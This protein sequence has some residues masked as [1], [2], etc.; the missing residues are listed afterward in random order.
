MKK[1]I[2]YSEFLADAKTRKSMIYRPG[3]ECVYDEGELP[4]GIDS[5]EVDTVIHLQKQ[6]SAANVPGTAEDWLKLGG[7]GNPEELEM[8]TDK[9]TLGYP[10]IEE[11]QHHKHDFGIHEGFLFV[12]TE[13][14]NGG[15]DEQYWVE[16]SVFLEFLILKS[17]KENVSNKITSLSPSCSNTQYPSAKC[18]HD[19]LKE[20][21]HEPANEGTSGQA[22]VTDG[23]GGRNWETPQGVTKEATVADAGNVVLK[24]NVY[25]KITSIGSSNA[26]VFTFGPHKSGIVNEYMMEFTTGETIP[27]VTFPASVKFPNPFVLY[28][29]STY[30]ISIINNIALYTSVANS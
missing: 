19:A 9:T 15:F 18:V 23:D 2:K 29:N 25:T 10:E 3:L 8:K 7:G 11:G 27:T 1:I 14:Y 24:S 12:C 20:K 28:V 17:E 22:L 21:I 13:D 5:I 26:L 4:E 16:S 30:Q 6:L